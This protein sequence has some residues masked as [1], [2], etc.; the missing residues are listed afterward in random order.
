MMMSMEQIFVSKIFWWVAKTLQK[1][2]KAIHLTYNEINIIVYYFVI[3][4]TWCIMIDYLYKLP[5][6]TT[7]WIILWSYIIITKHKIF[8]QWCDIIF[9]LSV[10]FL[11][12]FQKIGWDYWTAS[13]I[14][15]VVVP[16]IIYMVLLF[17]L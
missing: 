6:L 13:V 8:S 10:K 4:L 12:K 11:L 5:I 9:K 1:I 15:C 17:L 14:I 7:L 16:I 2:A 3:P